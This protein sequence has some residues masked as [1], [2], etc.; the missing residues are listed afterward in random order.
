MTDGELNVIIER[1]SGMKDILTD[2]KKDMGDM[3]VGANNREKMITE[4]YGICKNN[5]QLFNI[6]CDE[7][8]KLEERQKWTY[9]V[10][11][12][13]I[14]FVVSLTVKIIWNR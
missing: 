8:K 3:E 13:I 7:H 14:L 9:G 1:I 5:I 10:M 11:V 12:T 4:L 6:H 2:M